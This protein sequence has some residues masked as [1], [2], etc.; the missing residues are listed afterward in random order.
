MEKMSNRQI[1]RRLCFLFYIVLGLSLSIVLVSCS[2]EQKTKTENSTG[3]FKYQN[4]NYNSGVS[5][6]EIIFPLGEKWHYIA[7]HKPRPAWPAPAKADLWHEIPKLAPL[8]TYD[9]AF[10]VSVKG[11]RLYFA[12]SADHKI[13]CLDTE[14]GSELWSFF[15]DG[16][17]RL[18]PTVYGARLYFGSDD[19]NIYCLDAETGLLIWKKYISEKIRKIPGNSQI[20][21]SCPVRTG[22]LIRNDTLFGA[23]GLFPKDEVYTFAINTGDGSFVWKKKQNDLVPQGYPVMKDS[24]LYIPGSRSK[25]FVFNVRT[26]ELIKKLGGNP[27]DYISVTE[28]ELFHGISNKGTIDDSD[29]L[30]AALSGHKVIV[31]DDTFYIASDF[32]VTAINKVDYEKIIS[33]RMLLEKKI[34][35]A[36][37][38]L[39]SLRNKTERGKAQIE[40]NSNELMD[41]KLDEILKTGEEIEELKDKE[42][43]WRRSINLPYSMILCGNQLVVGEKKKVKIIDVKTGEF[44]WEKEVNGDPYG[45]AVADDKLF[46]STDKG[47]IHCYSDDFPKGDRKVKTSYDYTPFIADKFYKNTVETLL[48]KTDI[49]QGYCF[50]LDCNLGKLANE[51]VRQTDLNVIGIEKNQ[52]KVEKARILLDKAGLYGE[53]IV[54]FNGDLA[55]LGFTDYIA[56]MVLSDKILRHDKVDISPDKI[57][58]ILK[59]GKGI[60]ILGQPEGDEKIHVKDLREWKNLAG[61]TEWKIDDKHG[62]WLTFEPEKLVGEG[63]WTDLYA[64]PSNTACSGDKLITDSL[65]PQWFGGP[66]PRNMV[67]RHHRGASPLV[68]DGRVIIPGDNYLACVDAYNGFLYWEKYIPEFRRLGA[69]KDAGIISLREDYLYIALE[70]ICRLINPETGQTENSFI[71]PQLY[72]NQNRYWSYISTTGNTLVGSARKPEAIYNTLSKQMDYE[73]CWQDYKELVTSD[74]LFGMD[75]HTGEL[76]WTWKN[77]VII[78]NC[79][80]IGNNIVYFIESEEKSAIED[81]DGLITLEDLKGSKSWLVA[82]DLETGEKLWQKFID[83]S[84]FQHIVYLSYDQNTLVV[85]GSKNKNGTVWYDIVAFNSKDGKK[86]WHQEKNHG[87]GTGGDHGE[88]IHHP[89]IMNS[90]IYSEPFAFDLFSGK[91]LEGFKLNREGHGCGTISASSDKLFYR[92]GNPAFCEVPAN[93]TGDKINKVTRAGCWINIIPAGGLVIIPEASSGCTCDFPLQTSIVYLPVRN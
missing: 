16:P 81:K 77:G 24:L 56:N 36:A 44:I 42:F 54:I 53:R 83:L 73:L 58:K 14:T 60:V 38:E 11:K 49:R 72:S 4:D 90:V 12:S 89:V 46:V 15:T 30:S 29:F 45:L 23:A 66:G 84:P 1:D 62:V 22:I 2:E 78:N 19:G 68:L 26:G 13:Y 86:I 32:S 76:K 93:N 48:E 92:A 55:D 21:S 71:L 43:L 41:Q 50:I 28:K 37:D 39:K 34:S 79:I 51:I 31:R 57:E 80:A 6:Q 3:W 85:T 61:G 33:Q 52:L 65:M 35:D 17:N 91:Q 18:C 59:P 5:D 75:R 88:Q 40:G 82:L 70:G 67:D 27:G 64:N 63:S 69:F 9:R 7:G 20:I 74:Y 47:S 10:H 25:P 87:Y 8:I